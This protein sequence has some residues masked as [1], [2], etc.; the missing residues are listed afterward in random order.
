MSPVEITGGIFNAENYCVAIT[1]SDI[2]I[3]G[4]IFST[5]CCNLNMNNGTAVLN[6]GD[7]GTGATF[8]G[9]LNV[10]GE[11]SGSLGSMLGE[12]AAYW[13]GNVMVIPTENQW[14]ITGGD[15]VIKTACT[16]E[17]GTQSEVTDNADGNAHVR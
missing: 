3:T 14:K 15:V 7:D 8:L 2:S 11:D 6:V 4:G 9:G 16:H 10:T 5:N 13:Q 1:D 12:G 17:N